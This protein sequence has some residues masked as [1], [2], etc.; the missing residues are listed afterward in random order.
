[1]QLQIRIGRV[2]GCSPLDRLNQ[3]Y[4]FVEK[5]QEPVKSVTQLEAG[6]LLNVYV[7]DG[8]VMAEV[9]EIRTGMEFLTESQE[10]E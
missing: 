1:M 10:T 3:G 2:K 8:S 4:S 5:E 7:R 6:D 9:K